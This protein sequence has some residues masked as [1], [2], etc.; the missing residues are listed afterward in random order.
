MAVSRVALSPDEVEAVPALVIRPTWSD[1]AGVVAPSS[2]VVSS[3]WC[4]VLPSLVLFLG[5]RVKGKG[6]R[7]KG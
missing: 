6:L 5:L 1:E 2:C 3:S 7:V 4:P